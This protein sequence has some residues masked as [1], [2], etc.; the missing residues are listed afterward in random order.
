MVFSLRPPKSH[1]WLSAVGQS[2][3]AAEPQWG[4]IL[5]IFR[6]LLVFWVHTNKQVNMKNI[7]FLIYLYWRSVLAPVS[8]GPP[9]KKR[10]VCIIIWRIFARAVFKPWV[11]IVR[12]GRGYYNPLA[13]RPACDRWR[14]TKS[15]WLVKSHVFL[16][17]KKHTQIQHTHK[18]WN[19]M[20]R[21]VWNSV[22]VVRKKLFQ[23]M[24]YLSFY[25]CWFVC[26]TV[27]FNQKRRT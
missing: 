6:F 12:W 18:Y 5:L 13:K 17:P 1:Q 21:H 26:W 2:Q 20:E 10:T 23:R 3:A 25:S 15:E 19:V 24:S 7:V 27:G 16:W 14:G 8:L 11:E 4:H 22:W 9:S